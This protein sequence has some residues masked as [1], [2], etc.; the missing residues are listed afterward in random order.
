ME[1]R[2]APFVPGEALQ[3]PF[4]TDHIL[5]K[6]II[7]STNLAHVETG[8]P[9]MGEMRIPLCPGIISTSGYIDTC[10]SKTRSHYVDGPGG[11]VHGQ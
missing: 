10:H 4:N 11:A 1:I 7:T 8:K 5:L 9:A 6:W 3:A 2:F